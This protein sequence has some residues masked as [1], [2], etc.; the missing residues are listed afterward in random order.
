MSW[1]VAEEREPGI[2]VF[3][4]VDPF[5]WTSLEKISKMNKIL[6]KSLGIL[7]LTLIQNPR[8]GICQFRDTFLGRH[9][10]Q[11]RL[12]FMRFISEPRSN[13]FKKQMAESDRF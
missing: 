2:S 8:R 9:S 13:Q 7:T 5:Y 11:N 1:V 4:F 3:R 12:L 6:N 10:I